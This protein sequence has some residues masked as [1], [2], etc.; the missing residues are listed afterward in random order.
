[1]KV[2]HFA[3][4]NPN[5]S[6]QYETVKDLIK[7]E[8]HAGINAE[9]VDFGHKNK[10]ESRI[11]LKDEHIETVNLETIKDADLILRHSDIP[12]VVK[13][14][15]IPIVLC[16]HG[17][18]ENSFLLEYY[19]G[20]PII[21]LV[22]SIKNDPRYKGFITFWP[23]YIFHWS[24]LS[25][26]KVHYVPAPV[27]CEKYNCNGKRYD[28][29]EKSGKPNIM[30][31][32]RWR[33][34]S[35]PFNLL[36]AA[37]RFKDKYCKDVKVHLYGIPKGK[38]IGFINSLHD[39]FGD[40]SM[41]VK[42]LEYVY[43]SMDILI[44]SHNIATRVI[45]EGLASGLPIVAGSGCKYTSFTADSRDTEAYAD[46]INECWESVKV[47]SKMA[48]TMAIN[49]AQGQF[50]LKNVGKCAKEVFTQII[51]NKEMAINWNDMS[52]VPSD[53]KLLD[54]ITDQFNV[55]RMVEFGCGV[56]TQHFD[57]KKIRV[58]GY[59]AMDKIKDRVEKQTH[60]AIIKKWDG[61]T[62][63]VING[64]F[65]MAF[66]D[67]PMYGK[68]REPSYKA[69][70]NSAINLVACHDSSRAED[71]KWIKKYFGKWN[72]IAENKGENT[73]GLVILERPKKKQ[74]V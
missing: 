18:P 41:P 52:I 13:E 16:L 46:K 29:K 5:A 69:V 72:L 26:N 71:Q 54:K 40:V 65:Q 73:P 24:L 37:K 20:P 60:N 3:D 74:G 30:I 8:R 31:V 10:P 28:L 23:E 64:D 59:E 66:I 48:R 7:A 51:N 55:K 58:H 34:D 70:K 56:S 47:N 43:R 62:P 61:K 67:G 11:G 68:N 25:G 14:A 53:W 33:E 42:G 32:D 63:P 44:T 57:K 9:F 19:D 6:G 12:K 50:G 17:R 1:M 38:R 22:N 21:S 15:G 36:F 27:D 4:F 2:V 39:I 45:R 49:Y 35:T